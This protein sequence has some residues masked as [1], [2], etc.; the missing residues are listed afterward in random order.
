MLGPY[1][2]SM[3]ANLG[4][5]QE[6]YKMLPLAN[7]TLETMTTPYC[8]QEKN[9]NYLDAFD[10]TEN[11][12]SV[13]SK[14]TV[15]ADNIIKQLHDFNISFITLGGGRSSSVQLALRLLLK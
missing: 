13:Y 5:P 15:I 12:V 7:S 10:A 11:A 14:P 2:L 4:L 8:S 6:T 3:T 1:K 9:T